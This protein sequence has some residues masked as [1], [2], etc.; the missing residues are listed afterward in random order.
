MSPNAALRVGSQGSGRG[1]EFEQQRSPPKACAVLMPVWG[2]S[3][4]RRF[5]DF[6]LPTLLAPGN[7][8]ALAQA[9]PTCF[10]LLTRSSDLSVI[11][12][13]P[14]W[15][16]LAEQCKT[17][18]RT[19]DDLIA[20]GNHHATITLAY[21]R[22]IRAASAPM[23]DTVFLFLVADYLVA[24][25]SLRTVLERIRAGASGVLAGSLQIAATAAVPQ[26]ADGMRSSAS[27]L[28]L[29]PRQLASWALACLHPRS[30]ASVV[31][32]SLLHDVEANRLFW[33][34][35][36][37]TLIGRFYLL[38][39]IGIRPEVTDF[40]VGAPCDYSFVPELCPSNNVDVL[41]D[42]DD[43]LA[44]EMQAD[45]RAVGALRW[46]HPLPPSDLAR[47]LSRWTTARHR[48]NAH[49]TLFFHAGDLPADINE[50]VAAASAFVADVGLSL[51]SSPQPHRGH[52]VWV[53]MMALQRAGGGLAP[54]DGDWFRLCGAAPPETGLQGLLW[55]LRL[56]MLGH[57]PRVT[58][59]HPRWPDF[60]LAH[61]AL[62]ARLKATDRLLV[63]SAAPRAFERWLRPLCATINSIETELISKTPHDGAPEATFDA[64]LW[65]VDREPGATDPAVIDR[66]RRRLRP[67]GSLV[68]FAA[69]DRDDDPVGLRLTCAGLG[70]SLRRSGIV[71]EEIRYTPA[72]PVRAALHGAM[73]RA[74]RAGGRS[75]RAF[76]PVVLAAGAMIAGAVLA[77]NLLIW[78]RRSHLPPRGPCSSVLVAG[79]RPAEPSKSAIDCQNSPGYDL[80]MPRGRWTT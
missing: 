53:G 29:A 40:V 34:V 77:G 1:S 71:P 48:Q 55:R 23:L 7:I 16:R 78:S 12:D 59:C 8:P 9:L 42:S 4:V 15:R 37:H 79:R 51:A 10:V 68:I 70:L 30:A 69:E 54:G 6:C 18:I 11:A 41:T 56:R 27:E 3:F 31:N 63:V 67:G 14:A 20:E 44:V 13:H 39:M 26:S 75:R 36:E 50:F 62:E 46:G 49:S 60:H 38:H 47:S 43:Y 52:P 74:I 61:A 33:S 25:G 19:I 57:P 32:A 58:P 65:V 24:D 72:G 80:P 45:D 66:I 76:L 5:L 21:A 73:A 28:V 2:S 64:C 17:D 22:G 35:D